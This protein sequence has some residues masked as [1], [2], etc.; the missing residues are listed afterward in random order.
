VWA[1]KK[2]LKVN[3]NRESRESLAKHYA[4]TAKSLADTGSTI[5][6]P[7]DFCVSVARICHDGCADLA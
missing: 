3:L 4:L 7:E 6:M 5:I 2:F 1:I